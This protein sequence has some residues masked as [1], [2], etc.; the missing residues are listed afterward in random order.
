MVA[1]LS[2]RIKF[3]EDSSFD[4]KSYCPVLIWIIR[5]FHLELIDEYGMKMTHDDYLESALEEQNGFSKEIMERNKIR[6]LIKAFFKERH[7]HTLVRP[8][9]EEKDLQELAANKTK[10]RGEFEEQVIELKQLV[11]D[12]IKL[13]C[14]NGM[15]MTGKAFLGFAEKIVFCLNTGAVYLSII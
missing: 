14:I 3:T 15:P 4:L 6:T 8:A 12:S 2:K 5:D 1:E 9:H 10:M 7:C 13:K 11:F